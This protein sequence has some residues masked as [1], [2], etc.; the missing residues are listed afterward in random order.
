M[1]TLG[2]FDTF[3]TARLGIYAAQKGLAVTGNNISNINTAGY[4]RQRIQQVS[5][6]TGAHDT[7]KS[8]YDNHV[9]TGTL[10]TGINQIRDPYLDIRYRNTSSEVGYTDTMLDGLKSIATILDEVG[11][12]EEGELGDGILYAQLQ[13]VADAL[14]KLSADPTK[15]NDGLVRGAAESMVEL[16]NKY[17]SRLETL[18]V[19]TETAYKNDIKSVNEILTNIRNLNES[20]RDCDIGGDPALEL[21]DERNRQIDALSEYMHISVVYSM[22]DVGGGKEVEK[23]TI[24]LGNSNPD[25][26][27]YTDSSVLIDGVFGTQVS[28]PE[29]VPQVNPKFGSTDPADADLK[30]FLYLDANGDGTNDPDAANQLDNENYTLRLGK[31]LDSRNREW[32]STDTEWTR[33]DA[34]VNSGELLTAGTVSQKAVY[35]WKITDSSGLEAGDTIS[36]DGTL[37]TVGTEITLAAAQNPNML[38][39]FI[40]NKLQGSA[41]SEEYYISSVNGNITF[42]AKEAGAVGGD[43]P[44]AAATLTLTGAGNKIT[45]DED[46]NNT[47]GVDAVP[48]TGLDGNPVG[49]SYAVDD[50]GVETEV[51]WVELENGWHR[52]TMTTEHTKEVVLDDN[53][54]YGSLQATRELLTEKGEFST[55]AEVDIDEN[56]ATKRGIPYYQKSLDLLARQFATHYN[57]LNQGF[58]FNEAGNYIKADGTELTMAD[59]STVSKTEGLTPAQEQALKDAGLT[60]EQW[61]KN[62]GAGQPDTAGVLFSNRNDGDLTDN[63]TASNIAISASWSRGDTMIV[64]TYSYLYS[65]DDGTWMPNTTQNENVNHMITR[66]DDS[67]LYD[68]RD[69]VPGA[70]SDKLF[71]GSFN[72]MFSNMC[73]IEGNDQRIINIQL[74]TAYTTY[75]ELDS[76]REGVSGVDLN[77]EAMNMM[78]YQ[79]AYSA[80]CRMMTVIDEVLDRLINN[81]GVAGR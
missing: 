23:L 53:D 42:T 30:D 58:M 46:P 25:T 33:A 31:L 73:T 81:T 67:L 70:I 27:V 45:M 62:A 19:N 8:I 76:S 40:A 71:T 65:E 32:T 47:A 29:K 50:K 66:I 68:P 54:L 52:V 51:R 36:I 35:S 75:V 49:P 1:G 55:P 44:A 11:K 74:N 59:G 4:T 18:R 79:K 3:T 72:D 57:S 77:D 34:L 69:L 14:R 17:A 60:L 78:Q 80:A 16:F 26:A 13:K 21:R 37:Y 5:L 24:S 38:A 63:I 22:E 48:P 15:S 28:M 56:A 10:V 64:T 2:T 43:G 41:K 61:L 6:K 39:S 7:Y 9:G 20:I 12:G